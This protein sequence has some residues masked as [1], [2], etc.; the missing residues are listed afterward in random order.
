MSI[1]TYV[2]LFLI[3]GICVALAVIARNARLMKLGYKETVLQ[4]L[5]K[6]RAA[7]KAPEAPASTP[8]DLPPATDSGKV[9]RFPRWRKRK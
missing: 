5:A 9:V 2:V 7:R 4:M 8:P 1:G 3:L 6:L